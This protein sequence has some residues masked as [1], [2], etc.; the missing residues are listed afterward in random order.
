MTTL[1]DIRKRFLKRLRSASQYFNIYILCAI[2]ICIL[3]AYPS[4]STRLPSGVA[5]VKQA[6][7]A[8]TSVATPS[9]IGSDQW[10]SIALPFGAQ[11][12]AAGNVIHE[13][14]A[15]DLPQAVHEGQVQAILISSFPLSGTFYLGN[16]EIYR[17]E[18]GNDGHIVR[19]D[20]PILINLEPH[21]LALSHRLYIKV[22]SIFSFADL[23]PIY[24]G[25]SITLHQI[26]KE[27]LN[28][29]VK[30]QYSV[31]VLSLIFMMFFLVAWL[32]NRKIPFFRNMFF[33]SLFWV[34]WEKIV[35]VDQL[36]IQ[37]WILW[38]SVNWFCIAGLLYFFVATGFLV[39]NIKVPKFLKYYFI[40]YSFA[41]SFISW[42]DYVGCFNLLRAL[43]ASLYLVLCFGSI[44]IFYISW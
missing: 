30:Q 22:D 42:Y 10:E 24:F 40:F 9:E 23:E 36:T 34:V 14:F 17:M 21:D 25:S 8:K 41:G 7:I 29:N 43:I 27:Y 20:L 35:L 37:H 2:F 28:W 33:L 19:N 15:V 5:L 44:F 13:W 11:Y 38:R 39:A 18:S 3:Y 26:Y 16:K 32:K 6:F 1:T 12:P 4:Y 31:V